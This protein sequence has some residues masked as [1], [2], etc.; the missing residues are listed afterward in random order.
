MV[1]STQSQGNITDYYKYLFIRQAVD[2]KIII[3]NNYIK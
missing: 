3:P 2:P 1:I